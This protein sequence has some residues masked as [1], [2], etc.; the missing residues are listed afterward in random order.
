MSRTKDRARAIALRQKGMSYSQI[1]K[2]LG[3][4]KS[5]LSG[6]LKDMPLSK[7]RIK[8]L[9]A[10]SPRRIERFRETMRKKKKARRA[11]VYRKVSR[12]I[13]N[14]KNVD[15]ITGFYLYW[16][17]GTK[18]AE[19]TVSL[20]NSD[21]AIVK[22]FVE[23][24]GIL[25]IQPQK[26]KIKLH[27]YTDQ[28]EVKLKKFWSAVTG[29]PLKNFYKTYRKNSRSDE[30][31][32]KGMFSHGTCVVIYSNRDVYEYVLEGVAYLRNKYAIAG[33]G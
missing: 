33:S 3:I 31:T 21:P 32:Y 16:G 28:N 8:E 4:S 26:M 5:T 14:S 18:T 23:W 25:G 22:C 11:D 9:R 12:D 27:L 1:K 19:Y 2:E 24:M 10:N 13:A 29:V 17:E 30:K 20:T 6:W 7:E 15:F